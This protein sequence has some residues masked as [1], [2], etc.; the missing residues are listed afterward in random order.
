MPIF[1]DFVEHRPRFPQH[2][3]RLA[4]ADGADRADQAAY[5]SNKPTARTGRCRRETQV[6]RIRRVIVRRHERAVVV[7]DVGGRATQL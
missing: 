7:A 3:V 4:A 5:A 1:H 6:V 2:H